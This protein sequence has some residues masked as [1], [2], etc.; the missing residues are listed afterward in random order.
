MAPSLVRVVGGILAMGVVGALTVTPVAAQGFFDFLFGSQAPA[1]RPEMGRP[2]RPGPALAPN[3]VFTLP[4]QIES[5]RPRRP[6][7]QSSLPRYRTLCVRLC[8]GYYFPISFAATRSNFSRDQ[9]V[10][11]ARCPGQAV[12][13]HVPSPAGDIADAR[14]KSGKLYKELPTAFRYRKALVNACA[15]RPPPWSVEE[16]LRHAMYQRVPGSEAVLGAEVIAGSYTPRRTSAGDAAGHHDEGGD[17]GAEDG[18]SEAAD[19]PGTVP[20]ALPDGSIGRG[21]SAPGPGM[22]SNRVTSRR[23]VGSPLNRRSEPQ[24]TAA[25]TMTLFGFAQTNAPAVGQGQQRLRFPGD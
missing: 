4:P 13:F 1:A 24:P 25:S 17:V 19:G 6:L 20:D 9:K 23:V 11:E 2:A 3:Q 10:C 18:A 22:P 12:L 15:C 5:S 14:D 21:P 16:R 8:D 7:S